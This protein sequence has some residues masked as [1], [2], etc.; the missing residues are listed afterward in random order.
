[1]APTTTSVHAS[2]RSLFSLGATEAALQ[3]IAQV[4]ATFGARDWSVDTVPDCYDMDALL[5]TIADKKTTKKTSSKDGDDEEEWEAEEGADNDGEGADYSYWSSAP[6]DAVHLFEWT[7]TPDQPAAAATAASSGSG[8]MRLH[9]MHRRRHLSLAALETP[10]LAIVVGRWDDDRVFVRA[11]SFAFDSRPDQEFGR[12]PAFP[13]AAERIVP[14]VH[15]D[16]HQNKTK[17]N[18]KNSTEQN[19]MK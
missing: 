16:H 7:I 3:A 6:R 4:L 13:F 17:Q 9:F 15:H 11:P 5:K 2:S 10:T 14:E 1:M 8:A 18:K 12:L 19:K